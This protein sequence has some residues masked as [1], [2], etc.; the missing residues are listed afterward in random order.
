MSIPGS[1]PMLPGDDSR[2]LDHPCRS[3]LGDEKKFVSRINC[4]NW[5]LEGQVVGIRIMMIITI[6]III[7]IIIIVV[8][9]VVVAVKGSFRQ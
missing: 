4:W 8:V 3:F 7:I 9:V 6:I 2:S 5:H 1:L